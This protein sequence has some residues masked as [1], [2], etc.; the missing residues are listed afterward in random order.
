MPADGMTTLHFTI[1]IAAPSAAVRHVLLDEPMIRQWEASFA[2]SS[3]YEGDWS[4]GS[5]IRF[6][7]PG[8]DGVVSVIAKNRP[9]EYL[10]IRHVGVVNQGIDDTASDELKA[11]APPEYEDYFTKTWPQP[12]HAVKRLTE[13]LPTRQQRL[14]NPANDLRSFSESVLGV[15]RNH[16]KCD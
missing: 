2:E 13:T 9:S 1:M 15:A 5:T 6:L 8:A 4:E 3:Y 10:S 11:S 16:I 14:T 12:L 7:T